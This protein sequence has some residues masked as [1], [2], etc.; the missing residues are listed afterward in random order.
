VNT[1][2]RDTREI[3]REEQAMRGQILAALA[4]GPLTVPELA[5]ALGRPTHEV[6]YWV[7]AMRRYG[8]LAEVPGADDDGYFR[9]QATGRSTK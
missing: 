8:W 4:G 3:V 5:Q 2:V 6:V 7:M 1:T 9:Y